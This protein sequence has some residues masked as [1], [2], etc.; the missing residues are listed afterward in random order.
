LTARPTLALCAAAL[1]ALPSTARAQESGGDLFD[2]AMNAALFQAGEAAP[3][4]RCAAVFR[5]FRVYA[6]DTSEIGATAAER[7]TDL[8]VTAVVVWQNETATADL[9]AAFAAIVPMVTDATDLFLARMVENHDD[10][11]AVFD[12]ALE[13]E[14]AYCN[15]LHAEITAATDR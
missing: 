5:A 12:D 2:R 4:M 10:T 6:G 3:L 8:A 11:G 7:E 9:Q 13:T 15:A 1:F 14:L